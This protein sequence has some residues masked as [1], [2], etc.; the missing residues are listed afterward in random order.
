MTVTNAVEKTTKGEHVRYLGI[1]R[2]F[3]YAP[4]HNGWK[5]RRASL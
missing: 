5:L 2:Q 4:V 3:S 1:S